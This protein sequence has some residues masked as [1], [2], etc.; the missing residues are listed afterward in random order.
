MSMKSLA[1]CVLFTA[2]TATAQTQPA[3]T[4]SVRDAGSAG[5]VV[6]RSFGGVMLPMEQRVRFDADSTV[7]FLLNGDS[8]E[9]FLVVV[10]NSRAKAPNSS[11]SLYPA[12]DAALR[13]SPAADKEFDVS[14]HGEG[15]R[16]GAKAAG[17]PYR[18]FWDYVTGAGDKLGLRQDTVPAS[19]ENKLLQF[20]DSLMT[21]INATDEPVRTALRQEMALN[22]LTLWNEIYLGALYR[23]GLS[24]NSPAGGEDW[25]QADGRMVRWAR[26][27][28]DANA[29]SMVFG[30]V[31]S[32]EWGKHLTDEYL[33]ALRAA[34]QEAMLKARFS[35]YSNNYT[36]KAR[37]YLLANLIYKDTKDSRFTVGLDSLYTEFTA[38][39]PG[40]AVAPLLDEAVAKNLAI[41]SP[42]EADP[43]IRFID[44]AE[45]AT[46]DSILDQF[47]GKPLLVDVWA[48]WCGPCRRSFEHA[49]M[50]RDFAREHGI[51]LLYISVDE[52]DNR[53]SAVRKLVRAYGLKGNHLIMPMWLKQD[54]YARFGN[55]NGVLNIPSIALFDG[56]GKMLQRRFPESEDAPALLKAIES[57]LHPSAD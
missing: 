32:N 25:K 2:F 52:G 47:K 45:G 43:D 36:G 17:A 56:D 11:I 49:D 53:D 15:Q 42:A 13:I 27:D 57:T 31:A 30:D 33:D 40:S 21:I 18:L 37:E 46:L 16:E 22:T 10:D 20:A 54:I 5:V 41:N 48:T 9:H 14:G 1:I 39:Y 34:G 50:I 26:L 3:L 28:S 6:S 4:L 44:V 51:E 24:V 35:H 23:A 7:S 12:G 8:P 19:V 38:L 55:N 29:M